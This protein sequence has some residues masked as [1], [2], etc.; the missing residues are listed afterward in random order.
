MNFNPKYQPVLLTQEQINL[1]EPVISGFVNDLAGDS[2]EIKKQR[3]P[4]IKNLVHQCVSYISKNSNI[5]VDGKSIRPILNYC[6]GE[7]TSM[8]LPPTGWEE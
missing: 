3:Y 4:K 7:L 2:Y 8:N 6:C 5:Q 1:V